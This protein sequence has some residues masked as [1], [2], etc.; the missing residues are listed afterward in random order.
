MER[1]V[2]N[3]MNTAFIV[4]FTWDHLAHTWA[5][6]VKPV[7]GDPARIFVDLESTFVHLETRMAQ[8]MPGRDEVAG[9]AKAERTEGDRK[10]GK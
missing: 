9:Q 7:N 4:R 8:E 2:T 3:E 6:L 10:G 5:I 1:W